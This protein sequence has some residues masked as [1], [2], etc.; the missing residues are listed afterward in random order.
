MAL[1][2]AKFQPQGLYELYRAARTVLRNTGC[3][4]V[5]IARYKRAE[6]EPHYLPARTISDGLILMFEAVEHLSRR[7]VRRFVLQSARGGGLGSGRFTLCAGMSLI[8]AGLT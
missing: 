1:N 7:D 8:L 3:D 6:L 2:V 4:V 5:K